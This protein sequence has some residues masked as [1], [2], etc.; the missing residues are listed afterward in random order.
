MAELVMT[1]EGSTP[2]TPS[3]GR[4]KLYPKATGYAILDDASNE[5]PLSLDPATWSPTKTNITLGTGGTETAKYTQSGKNVIFELQLI[6]GS[7]GFAIGSSPH[8]T[9]PVT[10]MAVPKNTPIGICRFLDASAGVAYQGVI[11]LI[12]SSLV[13]RLFAIDSSST[14][15]TNSNITATVPFTWAASDEIEVAG[16]YIAA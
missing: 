2:A 16:Y 13:C 3:A 4:W 5:I 11:Q 14:Y 15:L 12:T 7:S 8:F 10:P 6:L 1:E 9:L